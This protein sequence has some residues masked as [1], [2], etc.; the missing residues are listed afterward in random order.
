MYDYPCDYMFRCP[1]GAQTWGDCAYFCGT[2]AVDYYDD[3][4][5]YDP[6]DEWLWC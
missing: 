4:D 2:D 5:D 3:P 1:Y 6:Y